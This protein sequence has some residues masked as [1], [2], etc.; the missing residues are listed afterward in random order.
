MY[1]CD[2]CSKEMSKD[3]MQIVKGPEIVSVSASGFVPTNAGGSL[4]AFSAQ[5]GITKAQIWATSVNQNPTTDWG[6]CKNCF[7]EFKSYEHTH[8]QFKTASN[9]DKDIKQIKYSKVK[10]RNVYTNSSVKVRKFWGWLLI[11]IG[12]WD[13]ISFIVSILR[14]SEIE[15]D[16][17]RFIVAVL[18]FALLPLYFGVRLLMRAKQIRKQLTE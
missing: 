9:V 1:K 2:I 18:L 6:L 8:H 16:I 3:E 4:A 14:K 17:S 11:V 7:A 13:T 12:A 15:P 10:V 5:M